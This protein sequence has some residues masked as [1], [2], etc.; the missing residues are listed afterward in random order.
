M[1]IFL[2]SSNEGISVSKGKKPKSNRSVFFSHLMGKLSGDRG[3]KVSDLF[4]NQDIDGFKKEMMQI[5]DEIAS[6]ASSGK[7]E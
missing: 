7:A 2:S 4:V 3:N 1:R 5:V 6:E